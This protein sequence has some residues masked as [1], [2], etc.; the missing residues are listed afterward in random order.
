MGDYLRA[1]AEVTLGKYENYRH[2]ADLLA[3]IQEVNEDTERSKQDLFAVCC[4]DFRKLL[5]SDNDD[6]V[7]LYAL[8]EFFDDMMSSIISN[9]D[10]VVRARL[11]ADNF[12]NAE[13]DGDC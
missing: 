12:D 7:P 1:Q 6:R 5:M 4:G 10:Y 13:Y 11:I 8:R 2:K 9:T 3:R